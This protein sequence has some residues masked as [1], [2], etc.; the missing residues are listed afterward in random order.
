MTNFCDTTNFILCVLLES[1]NLML[2]TLTR[3]AYNAIG[4]LG[5]Y[6]CIANWMNTWN[7]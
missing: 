5:N 4:G 7:R 1:I 6:S 3:Q 2:V